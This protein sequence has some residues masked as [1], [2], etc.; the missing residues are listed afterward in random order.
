MDILWKYLDWLQNIEK[1]LTQIEI[2]A[3]EESEKEANLIKEVMCTAI[4]DKSIFDNLLDKHDYWKFIR[5][6]TWVKQFITNCEGKLNYLVHWQLNKP[7]K[8]SNNRLCNLLNK[9][10]KFK[11]GDCPRST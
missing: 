5:I 10:I 8:V 6:T 1:W 4:D 7:M 9:I 11:Q 2:K 3:N